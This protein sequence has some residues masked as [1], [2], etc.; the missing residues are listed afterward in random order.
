VQVEGKWYYYW[1]R[2]GDGTSA[3]AGPLNA[4]VDY[5]THDVLDGIFTQDI[6]GVTGGGGNTTEIYRYAIINGVKL[7]LPTDGLYGDSLIGG[8]GAGAKQTGTSYS[9]PGAT[10]DA[11]P[12]SNASYDDLLAIWD[13]K[14]G[15]GNGTDVSGTPS[16]W[17]AFGYWSATPSNAGHAIV[18]LGNGYIYDSVDNNN[19]YVVLQVL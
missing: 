9:F 4:G 18:D 1:D 12:N 10:N 16:P 7:A 6:N 2:T 19:T 8:G 5:T 14:N 15:I 17:R 13:A 3:N 11:T